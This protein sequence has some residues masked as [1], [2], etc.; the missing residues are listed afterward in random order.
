MRNIFDKFLPLTCCLIISAVTKLG[1]AKDVEIWTSNIPANFDMN[2]RFDLSAEFAEQTGVIA[3]TKSALFLKD[4]DAKPW[5]KQTE[6]CPD[7]ISKKG[8][9]R[10]SAPPDELA[11]RI[12]NVRAFTSGLYLYS[13]PYHFVPVLLT[14]EK[15]LEIKK[16]NLY[17]CHPP[18]DPPNLLQNEAK[19]LDDQLIA[20]QSLLRDDEI[21][22]VSY[23]ADQGQLVLLTRC[24]QYDSYTITVVKLS[25]ELR[26]YLM[27]PQNEWKLGQ[28][29]AKMIAAG[30]A[31]LA[32][33]LGVL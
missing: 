11:E 25:A 19:E 3:F 17:H 6:F 13:S 7:R 22:S 2:T 29:K 1:L 4:Q 26:D 10:L 30:F 5:G 20:I 12:L 27:Q 14:I 24:L 8:S 31:A 33:W 21:V 28:L 23:V 9:Y 16:I 32:L 15:Y 18:V